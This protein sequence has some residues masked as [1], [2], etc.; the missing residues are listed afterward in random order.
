MPTRYAESAGSSR[1]KMV[2]RFRDPWEAHLARGRLEAEGIEAFVFDDQTV[3]VNWLYSGPLG[4]VRVVVPTESEAAALELLSAPVEVVPEHD[5]CPVCSSSDVKLS[6]YS[7]WSLL[8][9]LFF[10]APVFFPRRSWRCA[11]CGHAWGSGG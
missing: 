3:G 1:L 5:P 6:R 2:A 8:P 10:T 9:S 11:N 4:G 7:L